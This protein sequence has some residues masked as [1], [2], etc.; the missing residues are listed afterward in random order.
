[1]R[2]RLSLLIPLVP[3][4]LISCA[5]STSMEQ[6]QTLSREEELLD[7]YNNLA[8]V[9]DLLNTT[10]SLDIQQEQLPVAPYITTGSFENG[11][12]YYVRENGRPENRAELRLVVNV[13][14][15][16]EDEDQLGLAHFVEH[17]AFNGTAHFE[18]MEL[19]DYLESIGMSFGPSINASTSFDETMYMLTVPT[20]SIEAFE[21]AFLILEDWAHGLA[22]DHEEIDKERGVIIEEWRGGRGAGARMMDE[23]LPILFKDSRYAERLPIGEPDIIENFDPEVLKRF[24]RDWYRPDL[25]A[26]IAVGDFETGEVVDLIRRHFEH[27]ENPPSARPRTFFEV[28]DHAE[29]LFALATDP[30]ASGTG[31]SVYFKQPLRPQGSVAAYRQGLVE[32]LFNGILNRRLSELTQQ[33]DPPYLGGSSSQ[34]LFIRTKEVY[35]LSAGV[36]DDG[37]ERGL[38]ALLTEAERVARHGFT[39]TELDRQKLVMMRGIEQS[40][41]EREKRYSSTF[42][43]EYVRAFLYDE[44]IPGIEYEF[45]LYKRFVP[46]I[47]L[48][49]INRLAREWITE[50]NRVIMANGPEKEGYRLPTEDEFM[51]VFAGVRDAGIAPY[52]DTVA[53]AALMEEL[54]VP[55]SVVSEAYTEEIDVTEW[56]LSNGARVILKPTDFNEDQIIFSAWSPGGT[57]LLDDADYYQA[58]NYTLITAGGVS[59]FSA[60]DLQKLLSGKVAGA[61]IS[62]AGLEEGLNGSASP[63]DLETMFQLLYLRF[64]APR[65]DSTIFVSLKTRMKAS[66]ENRAASPVAAFL[67]TVTAI[68]SQ[69]HFRARPITEEMIDEWDLQRSLDFYRDRFADASDFTFLFIGNIDLETI[70]PLVERYIGGLP[71]IG[72]VETWRD[73]GIEYPSG[74]VKKE[75]RRGVEPQSQTILLFPGPFEYTR[76]NS[77]ALTS[78]TEV[79]NIRLREKIREELGGTYGV[80]VGASVSRRP[81]EEYSITIMFGADP[82]RMEELIGVVFDEIDSL[83]T[84][85]PT[86]DYIQKV[87]E[88]QRRAR[89]TNLRQNGYWMTNLAGRYR[90]GGDPR[91]ILTYE[92]IIDQLTPEMVRDAARKYFD[93]ENYLQFTLYPEGSIDPGRN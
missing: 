17:M 3:L 6:P 14:S 67:D 32:S 19:V 41:T 11:L 30:E 66:I 87:Q 83:G 12:R 52:V 80:N 4:L 57:S 7:K 81:E 36:E 40:F 63:K 65:A 86:P 35:S 76:L 68:V 93:L 79:L 13:G 37:I 15:I 28:P 58:N 60:V 48:D 69:N 54:P 59:E 1:M 47:T 74:V 10:S 64:T 16:V 50:E 22:F 70:R 27:L 23:Q 89:E 25:M 31:V 8:L 39:E 43:A 18:K 38:E 56:V 84:F 44:P 21:K 78:M 55:G 71:S 82:E 20:D 5:P 26:V 42:A 24:Y 9:T 75:V 53:D 73:V 2:Y 61:S 90:Y 33:A 92:A 72:R 45:D 62:I 46:G 88:S 91:E 51:A 77:Y 29:T 85:G 49:S 34:G